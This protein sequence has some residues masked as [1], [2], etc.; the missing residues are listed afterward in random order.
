VCEVRWRSLRMAYIIDSLQN[1]QQQ[2]VDHFKADEHRR[3]SFQKHMRNSRFKEVMARSRVATGPAHA[4]GTTKRD[5]RKIHG[6]PQG[7][8]PVEYY[9]ERL[10]TRKKKAEILRRGSLQPASPASAPTGQAARQSDSQVNKPVLTTHGASTYAR[11]ERPWAERTDTRKAVHMTAEEIRETLK[12]VYSTTGA[13]NRKTAPYKHYDGRVTAGLPL[14]LNEMEFKSQSAATGHTRGQARIT[15]KHTQAMLDLGSKKPG[16][17]V[18]P[19]QTGRDMSGRKPEPPERRPGAEAA[20]AA[21]PPDH[22]RRVKP[23]WRPDK[24]ACEPLAASDSSVERWAA[25]APWRERPGEHAGGE[26]RDTGASNGWPF[27]M[28]QPRPEQ[29][30]DVGVGGFRPDVCP[31]SARSMNAEATGTRSR[32]LH[33]EPEGGGWQG[34][35]PAAVAGAR[36]SLSTTHAWAVAPPITEDGRVEYRYHSE[37]QRPVSA[38]ALTADRQLD[39]PARASTASPQPHRRFVFPSKGGPRAVQS[40]R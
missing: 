39:A 28:L 22:A 20:T 30:S 25:A 17:N 2:L 33:A 7:Q 14:R 3:S 9:R 19:R 6:P 16:A 29:E 10:Q 21:A 34:A 40:A 8:D 38:V 24:A 13:T 35:I 31:S 15:T 5:G 32:K 4:A 11:A 37:S 27:R 36:S 18:A 12:Q 23:T 26:S 1:Y